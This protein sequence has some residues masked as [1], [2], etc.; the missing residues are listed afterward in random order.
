MAT[1]QNEENVLIA[2]TVSPTSGLYH[3]P[4][5]LAAAHPVL[6]RLGRVGEL[7]DVQL[8]AVPRQNWETAQGDV[9]AALNGL[10]G[11][12]RVDVQDSPKRRAK[13]G[14]DEL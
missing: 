13:R 2:V 1:A 5:S 6:L 10:A 14:G 9:L 11:V 12:L 4:D 3:D 8:L 7:Q